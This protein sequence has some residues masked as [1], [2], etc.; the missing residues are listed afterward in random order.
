MPIISFN[1]DRDPIRYVS[2]SLQRFQEMYDFSKV[3]HTLLAN[4]RTRIGTWVSG[5]KA[6]TLSRSS[7]HKKERSGKSGGTELWAAYLFSAEHGPNKQTYPN[8]I[9][10]RQ[11][12]WSWCSSPQGRSILHLRTSSLPDSA[13]K[14]SFILPTSQPTPHHPES[15]T[16]GGSPS[17]TAGPHL[18]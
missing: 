3:K 11:R 8:G 12:D 4:V 17:S 6:H 14:P 2:P 1:L 18:S 13:P 15:A 16:S 5:S 9:S 10:E 7:E